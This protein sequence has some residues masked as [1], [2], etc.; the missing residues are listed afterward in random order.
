MGATRVVAETK[1]FA[2][3]LHSPAQLVGNLGRRLGRSRPQV[4]IMPLEPLTN[5]C[6]G[7]SCLLAALS[8]IHTCSPTK[9]QHAKEAP[10]GGCK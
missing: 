4:N 5:F 6:V 2:E 3:G 8:S 10:F 7:P 1:T 9:P